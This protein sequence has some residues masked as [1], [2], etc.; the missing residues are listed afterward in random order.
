M[1][2]NRSFHNQLMLISIFYELT[3]LEMQE[4]VLYTVFKAGKIL[5]VTQTIEPAIK[6]I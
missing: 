2:I 1:K 5:K 4:W 3:F 6:S